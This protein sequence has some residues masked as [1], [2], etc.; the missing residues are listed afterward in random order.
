MGLISRATLSSIE[1]K[2]AQQDFLLQNISEFTEWGG[3]SWASL[4]RYAFSRLGSLENKRVLEIGFRSGKIT[5]LFALLGA[6]V[7]ALE[8]DASL[9]PK[10]REQLGRL[11]VTSNVSLLHYDGDI[12]HCKELRDGEFDVLFSKS[13]LVLLRDSLPQY[14]HK[15]DELLA[16]NGRFVFL[17]NA[18]GGKIFSLLRCLR[19][20]E[21]P[22][23]TGIDYFR[24]YH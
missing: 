1:D 2:R 19:S 8:V 18:Y 22:R 7:T 13:V 16:V 4:C 10:A 9:I 21:W 23:S 24:E 6:S 5:A 12:S 17:E 11:G 15:L 20:R 14:L 3:P